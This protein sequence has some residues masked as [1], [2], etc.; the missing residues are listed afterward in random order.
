V[1]VPAGLPLAHKEDRFWVSKIEK[2]G[3]PNYTKL[4]NVTPKKNQI[5]S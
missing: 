3:P 1:T 2:N 4:N 5:L